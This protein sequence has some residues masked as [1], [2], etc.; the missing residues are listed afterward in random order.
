[1]ARLA[2]AE[3]SRPQELWLPVASVARLDPPACTP[4]AVCVGAGLYLGA[5]SSKSLQ[6]A[7]SLLSFPSPPSTE[8]VPPWL[9]LDPPN[10][11]C[12]CPSAGPYSLPCPQASL[13]C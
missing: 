3:F 1:P 11:V 10:H 6:R 2:R 7:C 12:P 8:P 9:A 4:P 5:V 13:I